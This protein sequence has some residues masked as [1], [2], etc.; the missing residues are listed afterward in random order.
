MDTER[1]GKLPIQDVDPEWIESV[2]E[3][4]SERRPQPP[5]QLWDVVI[6]TE[7]ELVPCPSFWRHPILWLRWNPF[8][9][10]PATIVRLY[11]VRFY[12]NPEG[13]VEF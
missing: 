8:M 13:G 9:R 12:E 3:F 5:E 7:G 6:R 4:C 10:Q 11:G 1:S 2:F